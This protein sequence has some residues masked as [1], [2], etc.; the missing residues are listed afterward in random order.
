MI[1]GVCLFCVIVLIGRTSEAE[2]VL[3]S[4][5]WSDGSESDSGRDEL[6]V[7]REG[8]EVGTEAGGEVNLAK[9][10][11]KGALKETAGL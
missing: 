7:K 10:E 5:S 8:L 1:K 3:C 9:R 11:S 4:R 2:L 6:G